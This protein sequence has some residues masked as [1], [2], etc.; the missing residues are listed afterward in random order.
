[1][2]KVLFVLAAFLFTVSF[3]VA[4]AEEMFDK[5]I[6]EDA[7][8]ADSPVVQSVKDFAAEGC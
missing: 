6:A 4:A 2:K 1:M 8:H 7:S 5:P 3:S